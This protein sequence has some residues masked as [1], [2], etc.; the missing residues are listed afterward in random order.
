MDLEKLLR[1]LGCI[2]VDTASTIS[3]AL[4]ALISEILARLEGG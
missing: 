2:V 4:W 1:G 3:Q